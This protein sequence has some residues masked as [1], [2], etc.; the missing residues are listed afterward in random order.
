MQ[1]RTAD[2]GTRFAQA[3]RVAESY[4]RRASPRQPV[5]LLAT[6]ARPRVVVGLT[7]EERALLDGLDTIQPSDAGGRIEDAV[8]LA[9]DLLAARPG[10][11]RG[12]CWSTDHPPKLPPRRR[13]RRG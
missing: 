8:T 7:G 12:S 13:S 5:A 4:L 2:G 6:E 3:R 10:G 9:A 1:A 11:K